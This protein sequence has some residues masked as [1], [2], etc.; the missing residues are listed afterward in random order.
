MIALR[1][2]QLYC[3]VSILAVKY[4][5][6]NFEICE[7]CEE[8][9]KFFYE[10]EHMKFCPRCTVGHLS[11]YF[12]RYT[13]QE[14]KF[15]C[16]DIIFDKIRDATDVTF[17]GIKHN[18]LENFRKFSWNSINVVVS[19]IIKPHLPIL[20]YRKKSRESCDLFVVVNE[21][22]E[23]LNDR[24]FAWKMRLEKR[25]CSS[26]LKSRFHLTKV[27]CCK[28]FICVPCLTNFRIKKRKCEICQ[29]LLYRTKKE[30]DE[31]LENLCLNT[32]R[33]LGVEIAVRKNL[34]KSAMNRTIHIHNITLRDN[35]H[36]L[37]FAAI[38]NYIEPQFSIP[39]KTILEPGHEVFRNWG[40]PSSTQKTF[41]NFLISIVQMSL[42]PIN[43][44]DQSIIIYNSIWILLNIFFGTCMVQFRDKLYPKPLINDERID[45]NI[46]EIK[47]LIIIWLNY[48]LAF[49]LCKPTVFST[50]F[51]LLVVFSSIT[52]PLADKI[53][54][55]L[56][57]IFH[58]YMERKQK[59]NFF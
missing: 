55:S 33:I 45:K 31:L 14:V 3:V 20:E 53:S 4:N 2:L 59:Y 5:F 11:F 54:N 43:S 17:D 6:V 57:Q 47:N 28:S 51:E 42:I 40:V 8:N 50:H 18:P 15:Y 44:M 26:C 9:S 48:L 21:I 27:S 49:F 7:K 34:L 12:P 22:L 36:Q 10:M 30:L 38:M 24:M 1:L 25:C 39:W 58:N 16:T 32:W 19:D 52:I 56:K 13:I 41:T 35:T 23:G 29:N 46:D 37:K